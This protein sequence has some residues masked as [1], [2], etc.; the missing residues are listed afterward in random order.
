M[1]RKNRQYYVVKG[2][3]DRNSKLTTQLGCRL[4][5]LVRCQIKASHTKSYWF[6]KCSECCLGYPVSGYS[7]LS[8][9]LKHGNQLSKI[10]LMILFIFIR[11][12]N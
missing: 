9:E 6:T 8:W 4:N 1:V 3:L 5:V 12:C 7:F 2:L 10:S 11:R